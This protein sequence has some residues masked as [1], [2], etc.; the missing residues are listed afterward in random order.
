VDESGSG[1]SGSVVGFDKDAA[2]KDPLRAMEFFAQRAAREE[3]WREDKRAEKAKADA[4]RLEQ[5]GFSDPSTER[6]TPAENEARRLGVANRPIDHKEIDAK[7]DAFTGQRG[8][9]MDQFIPEHERVRMMAAAGDPASRAA[10][11]AKQAIEARLHGGGGGAGGLGYNPLERKGLGASDPTAP[12]SQD[13][14]YE[15][16]KKRMSTGYRYRPNPLGNPRKQYY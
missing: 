12:S 4:A 10:I 16:Y 7:Y 14:I 6:S 11:E 5:R 13:D 3:K 1:A 15:Q 2:V 8:H 9:H